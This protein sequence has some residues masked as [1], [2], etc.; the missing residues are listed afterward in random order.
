[1][2]WNNLKKTNKGGGGVCPGGTQEFCFRIP[3]HFLMVSFQGQKQF[4]VA[5][6]YQLCLKGLV[7]TYGC[8]GSFPLRIGYL[9][10]NIGYLKIN[11]NVEFK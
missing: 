4:L 3:D 7:S 8:S 11:I 1:M 10:I 9:K 6:S 2:G 5:S